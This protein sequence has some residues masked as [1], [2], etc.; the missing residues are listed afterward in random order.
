MKYLSIVCFI[1]I[2]FSLSCFLPNCKDTDCIIQYLNN[3]VLWEDEYI[4]IEGRKSKCYRE[5][6]KLSKYATEDE[7][8]YF[9]RNEKPIIKGYS[10]VSLLNRDIEKAK[11]LF[12][13]ELLLK[14]TSTISYITGDL[15]IT[16]VRMVEFYFIEIKEYGSNE[17][18][19]T[20]TF[21]D[22]VKQIVKDNN[23]AFEEFILE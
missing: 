11:N 4:G 17:E 6:I 9:I 16:D 13:N 21:V 14:D 2:S 3:Q 22:S 18:Y 8:I 5:G 20:R 10:F 12:K 23:I 7:L 19:L 15:I 1:I